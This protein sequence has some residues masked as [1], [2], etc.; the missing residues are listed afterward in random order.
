MAFLNVW[1]QERTKKASE[2][3]AKGND[4]YA[5]KDFVRAVEL[6]TQAIKVSPKADSVFYSNRAACQFFS[7][8]VL[9]Q[10][11]NESSGV[12]IK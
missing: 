11:A 8:S 4:A 6:Y 9:M 12:K 7:F 2:F 10:V 5:E 1:G 3:K